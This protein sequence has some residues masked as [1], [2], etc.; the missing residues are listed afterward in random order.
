MKTIFHPNQGQKS[1]TVIIEVGSYNNQ[2]ISRK[3]RQIKEKKI[4]YSGR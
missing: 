2:V 1:H 3:E 4:E